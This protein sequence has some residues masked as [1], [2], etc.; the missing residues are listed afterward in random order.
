MDDDLTRTRPRR[1]G[2]G[3]GADGADAAPDLYLRLVFS[4]G[5]QPLGDGGGGALV[6]GVRWLD[7]G[8][9]HVLGRGPDGASDVALPWD[10][11]ASRRHASAG[12]FAFGD[13]R[14]VLVEDLGSSNGTFLDGAPVAGQ[15]VARPGQVL[16]VGSS[17]FVVGAARR[18][19]PAGDVPAAL[20]ARAPAM[21]T[22]WRRAR[23]VAGTEDPALLLGEPGTGKTLVARLL[24][25]H[26]RRAG[27]PFI[28]LNSSAIPLHL[29][30]A[31]LFGVVP[32]FIPSVKQK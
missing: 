31:T 1:P 11:W 27:G 29:E 32:G 16:R 18:D 17:L 15:T 8:Q 7:K 20:H 25:E 22:L 24:H 23:A 28:V 12:M 10:A 9:R 14:G 13:E 30:E 6:D 3:P 4:E 21:R 5:R 19:E 26:S 2:D